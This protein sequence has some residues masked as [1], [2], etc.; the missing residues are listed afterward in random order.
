MCIAVPQLGGAVPKWTIRL[1][2]SL[3]PH[4]PPGGF[5]QTNIFGNL[6]HRPIEIRLSAKIPT[7]GEGVRALFPKWPPK[8]NIQPDYNTDSLSFSKFV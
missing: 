5:S 4:A 8:Y 7:L 3:T 2:A 6:V 1:Q